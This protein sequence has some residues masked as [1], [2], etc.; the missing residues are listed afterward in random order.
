MP[1]CHESA[2]FQIWYSRHVEAESIL[3]GIGNWLSTVNLLATSVD[4]WSH[5]L[6]IVSD[7]ICT[8]FTLVYCVCVQK[9]KST[10]AVAAAME[11]NPALHGVAHQNRV[12]ADTEET[13]NDTFFESLDGVANALD[14]VDASELHGE[15]G[16]EGSRSLDGVANALDNVDASELHGEEGREGSRCHAPLP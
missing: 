8:Y 11:M 14:N 12:C 16:R 6:C 13:Y 3:S 2:V 15:E 9:P 5:D 4:S 1:H 10:T 7:V